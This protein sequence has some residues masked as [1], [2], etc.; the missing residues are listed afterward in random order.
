MKLFFLDIRLLPDRVLQL[1]LIAK[2]M[3]STIE[4]VSTAVFTL[5]VQQRH[6]LARANNTSGNQ[7]L[8]LGT[9]SRIAHVIV[10]SCWI[11]LGLLKN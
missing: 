11:A 7:L 1:L 2:C 6:R 10:E 8:D 4:R 9:N 5:L 3:T